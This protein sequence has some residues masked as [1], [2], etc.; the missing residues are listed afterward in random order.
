MHTWHTIGTQGLMGSTGWTMLNSRIACL[1]TCIRQTDVL[2]TRASSVLLDTPLTTAEAKA[3]N[4]GRAPGIPFKPAPSDQSRSWWYAAG[5]FALAH[6][7]IV[8]DTVMVLA[9][10]P[11][12]QLLFFRSGSNFG[13]EHVGGSC[14]GEYSGKI[15]LL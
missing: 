1:R 3:R 7:Q 10:L 9:T 4:S 2:L 14:R 6:C 11:R 13:T 5:T 8:L 15:L 12:H